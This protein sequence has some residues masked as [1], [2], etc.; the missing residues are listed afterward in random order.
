MPKSAS[1]RVLGM[2]LLPT[3]VQEAAV[4]PLAVLPLCVPDEP[5]LEL[6]PE[7]EPEPEPELELEL[8]PAPEVV[9]EV[10][11]P[12]A[13]AP[14]NSSARASSSG[15]G[16]SSLPRRGTSG[17]LAGL[18]SMFIC[19]DPLTCVGYPVGGEELGKADPF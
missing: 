10:L 7:A 19:S 12:H 4:A 15:S 3:V 1:T 11:L 16:R 6:E 9:V 13:A 2:R 8:L 14:V 5:E 18:V 17:L